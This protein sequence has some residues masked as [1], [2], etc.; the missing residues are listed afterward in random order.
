MLRDF[1]GIETFKIFDR[2]NKGYLSLADFK[3]GIL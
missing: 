3:D 1:A 2:T